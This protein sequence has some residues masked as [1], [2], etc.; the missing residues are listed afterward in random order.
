VWGQKTNLSDVEKINVN[1]M[2]G[3]TTT[4]NIFRNGRPFDLR[5]TAV[6]YNE[7]RIYRFIFLT[8]KN[9]TKG[10]SLG[11]R[12]LTYSLKNISRA[13]ALRIKPA[14]ILVVPVLKGD[15]VESFSGRMDVDNFKEE[16]FRVLNGLAPSGQLQLGKLVKI[17]IN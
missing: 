17:I 3:A 1:G 6:R 4:A 14:R 11:L 16:T 5:L 15:S 12:Q 13:E 2:H 10:L 9:Q 8:P 7:K